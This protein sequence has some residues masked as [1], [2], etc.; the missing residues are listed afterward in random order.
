[1]YQVPLRSGR[2]S[3][4]RG[5]SVLDCADASNEAA[6][7]QIPAAIIHSFR[8]AFMSFSRMRR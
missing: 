6:A 2:P 4:P 1:L 5:T 7:T 8:L 3:G